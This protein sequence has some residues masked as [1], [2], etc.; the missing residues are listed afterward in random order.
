MGNTT[1]KQRIYYSVSILVSIGFGAALT[2]W[3]DPGERGWP[4][5]NQFL[6]GFVA[7]SLL[8]LAGL[9]LMAYCVG[10]A[11]GELRGL[12]LPRGSVRGMLALWM[13]GSYLLFLVFAPYLA[14]TEK[15]SD[16]VVDSVLKAFGP[17]VGAVLAFYFAARSAAPSPNKK[18][19]D[20]S[21]EE[22][23]ELIKEVKAAQPE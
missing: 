22:R 13:V 8:V 20:L 19:A 11:P 10:R 21:N 2:A 7:I 18:L 1:W 3:L 6:A 23:A 5:E 9:P 4:P 17:L 14:T 12:G 16:E 15:F